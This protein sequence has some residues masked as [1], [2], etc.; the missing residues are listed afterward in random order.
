[1]LPLEVVFI[2]L[3]VVWGLIGA[4]RGFSREI[5]ASIAIVLAMAT[6]S[7]FGPLVVNSVN[8]VAGKLT[9]FQIPVAA[10]VPPGVDAFCA[11]QSQEQ[12][13][14]YSLM[15]SLIVFM[16]YQGE[17]F[18]LPTKLAPLPGSIFGL[19]AGLING[20]LVA[21]NLWYFLDKCAKYNVPALGIQVQDAG[22]LSLTAQTIIKL[23]PLNLIGEPILL[24]GLLFLLLI[25]RIAK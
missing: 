4:V 8:K 23:L 1:M 9:T 2:L 25:L 21:G 17:T 14:F 22:V 6:L 18:G 12:F 16:G 10:T 13:V 7:F 19:F 24:V 15:F 3:V 20:W 11:A 5:G